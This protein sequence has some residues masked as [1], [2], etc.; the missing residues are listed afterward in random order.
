MR[1][2]RQLLTS[3]LAMGALAVAGSAI[4]PAQAQISC[5]DPKIVEK[6]PKLPDGCQKERI[7]ASGS[8]R[9]SL[10]WANRSA[11]NAWKDQSLT[12][13][14][15]R[16]I[17]W[18]NSACAKQ[19]CVPG[20]LAGFKRCTYSGFPCA[21]KP[22]FEDVYELSSSEIQELQ[23]LLSKYGFYRASADGKF[24]ERTS[25]AL[26]RW[27]RSKR[28]TDDGLPTRDNLEKLRKG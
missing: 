8:Q 19:E 13:F 25:E 9:P 2:L 3:L 27:Q 21:R 18:S 17:T 10:G 4:S 23:R 28:L 7:T 20:A 1:I 11:E 12:K 24:G 16:F 15:E 26:Q 5:D 6:L 22:V 14:G